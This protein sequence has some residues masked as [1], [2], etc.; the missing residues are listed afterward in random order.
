MP[1]SPLQ[2]NLLFS[3]IFRRIRNTGDRAD[4]GIGPY[5][6]RFLIESVFPQ[7]EPKK[8]KG[9]LEWTNRIALISWNESMPPIIS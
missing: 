6:Y 9:D 5:G 2:E 4:V 1:T 7:G 3:I 8:V